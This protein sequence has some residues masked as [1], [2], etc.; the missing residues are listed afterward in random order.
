MPKCSA[1]LIFLDLNEIS[2][3]FDLLLIIANNCIPIYC[4]LMRLILFI[5]V[6]IFMLMLLAIF[7]LS[8]N[9]ISLLRYNISL[10]IDSL[11]KFYFDIFS[12]FL[13]YLLLMSVPITAFVHILI[14]YFVL[15]F[16]LLR[17]DSKFGELLFDGRILMLVISK[18]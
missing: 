10:R 16:S 15:R 11:I 17:L 18:I 8:F 12:I 14:D 3:F 9:N 1:I 4:D 6:Q 2:L 5:K 13:Y 7:I